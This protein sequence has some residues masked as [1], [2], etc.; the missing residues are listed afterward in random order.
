MSN[1]IVSRSVSSLQ[2]QRKLAMYLKVGGRH[3]FMDGLHCELNEQEHAIIIQVIQLKYGEHLLS[4]CIL[5]WTLEIC[6]K[7]PSASIH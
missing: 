7:L 1:T 4:K 2:A 3:W 5:N 6:A